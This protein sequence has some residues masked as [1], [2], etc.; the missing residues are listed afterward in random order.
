FG[1]NALPGWIF[2]GWYAYPLA[3]AAIASL[4][5]TCELLAPY[6][7]NPKVQMAI[8]AAVILLGPLRAARYF[9]RHGPK[10]EVGDNSLVAS[11]M[12]L[13]ER[14]HARPGVYSMGAIAGV[15]T[16][17]LEKPVVQIEGLVADRAM[18]DHLRHEDPLQ[19]VLRDYDVDYLAL[20]LAY[21]EPTK[22]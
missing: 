20:S 12:Q 14:V 16:Y 9:D 18:I 2:F 8:G 3:T 21:E 5:F 6:V 13:A 15:A 11:S 1:L 7:K 19:Q 22:H 10:W 17:L 4:V